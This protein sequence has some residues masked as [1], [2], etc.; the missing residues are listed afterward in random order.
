MLPMD[1]RRR[2][3]LSVIRKSV[4]E[5]REQESHVRA[6]LIAAQGLPLAAWGPLRRGFAAVNPEYCGHGTGYCFALCRQQAGPTLKL[7]DRN[8]IDTDQP[9]VPP[10]RRRTDVNRSTTASSADSSLMPTRRCSRPDITRNT[11]S[12]SSECR[13]SAARCTPLGP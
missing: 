2:P 5:K 3:M 7:A 12:T 9:P 11:S 4:C 13:A 8:E 1:G 10:R 6:K